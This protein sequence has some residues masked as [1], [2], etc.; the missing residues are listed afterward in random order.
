MNIFVLGTGRCGTLTFYKACQH[1]TNY[2]CGHETK[3]KVLGDDRVKFPDNHIEIDNRLVWHLG[4]LSYHNSSNNYFIHLR[5]DRDSVA[6]SFLKRFNAG[7]MDAYR[8]GIKGGVQGD[9]KEI[10]LDYVD[11][12]EETTLMFFDYM[13]MKNRVVFINIEDPKYRFKKFWKDIGA[14]GDLEAALKEFDIKH[15]KS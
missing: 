14:Q 7:I 15:N 9:P 8:R 4:L 13:S 6:K 1:I 10:A 5:R 2:T 11:N 3:T 12:V